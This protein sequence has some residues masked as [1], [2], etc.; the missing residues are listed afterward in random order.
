M[1]KENLTLL[2]QSVENNSKLKEII[3]SYVGNKLNPESDEINIEQI[4]EVFSQEFP[5]FVLAIAEE[6]WGN[7]YSKALQDVDFFKENKR[8]D[9]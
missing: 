2:H 6:N 7:G 8:N 5:D 3:V 4:L 9:N 1:K